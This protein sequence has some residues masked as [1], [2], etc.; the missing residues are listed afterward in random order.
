MAHGLP[1]NLGDLS[2]ELRR[3]AE[4]AGL[5]DRS[6]I[7]ARRYRVGSLKAFGNAIVAALAAEFVSVAMQVIDHDLAPDLSI[8]N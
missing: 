1:K 8:A 2:P 7:L 5:D 3:M 4:V 6:L